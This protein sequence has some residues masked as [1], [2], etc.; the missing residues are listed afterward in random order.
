MTRIEKTYFCSRIRG[1]LKMISRRLLRIKALTALYALNRREDDDLVKGE[2]ELMFSIQKT[3]DL[4]HY[5]M[6]LILEIADI[7]EEKIEQARQKKVPAPEDLK[8]NR[9]FVDNLV[10]AKLR[11]TPSFTRYITSAKLSWIN[12]YHIVRQLYKKMTAWPVYEE[13]MKSSGNNYQ[14]DKKLII[15]ILNG[16]FAD[17][18]DL[19]ACLEEQSIYWNDDM[20]FVLMMIEKTLKRSLA[21]EDK[22]I[23]LM[24]L[25]KNEDDKDFVKILFRK[26]VMNNRKYSELIER[27]T[28]NWELERIALMDILVMRLAITEIIEFPEIPV[29]VTLNEYIEIAKYYCTSKSS[30]F[31]N[32]ILDNIVR[33]LRGKGLVEKYGR[34]LI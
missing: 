20:E 25:F 33:E 31:V 16:I 4:Y 29:R 27:N 9:R 6:L 11:N 17:S 22:D 28:T 13:Y 5:I 15:Q 14:L 18:E 23:P 21:D 32:G 8:P 12:Y 1:S 3:Y 10:I 26:S 7:A 30:T 24:P 34:G 19:A 2:K